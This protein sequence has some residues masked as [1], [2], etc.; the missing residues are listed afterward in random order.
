M[1]ENDRTMMQQNDPKNNWYL[2]SFDRFEKSLNG[3][4]KTNLHTIRKEAIAKFT[5]I[6]FPTTHDEEWKYTDVSPISRMEFKP[7]LEQKT[8]GLTQEDI[9]RLSFGIPNVLVLVNGRFSKELSKLSGLP[10]NIRAGS[11]ADALRSGG[12]MLE[13]H[14][15]RHARY[16]E[17]AF[18][19]LNTAFL[20]DGAFIHIPEKMILSEPIHLLFISTENAEPF[21]SHP[22]NLI[23]AEKSCQATILES[24]V[25]VGGST[26]FTNTVSEIVVSENAVLEH[27]KFQMESEQAFHVA[28]INAHQ[29]R[30]STYTQHVITMGGLLTRNNI[31]SVLDGE[32]IESTLNG[33]YLGTADQHIDNHTVIDHAKPHCN[34]HE[35]YKGILSGKSRGV[36]NG[37]IFVRKDAQ[38]T[39]AKQ[40]NKNLV[41][42]DEA[43]IDSKPQLEIFANDVKCTHGATIGQLDDEAIFYLRSRGVDFAKAR[44]ILI[45]AFASDVVDRLKIEP[46]RDHLHKLIHDRLEEERTPAV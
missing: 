25:S 35:L 13:Q 29:D 36:F 28:T 4:A 21:V 17:N 22:R 33:L 14:L 37:K 2:S 12:A 9:E 27:D 45:F 15:T 11:L 10:K 8:T 39:D 42:S 40:T 34:S 46:L 23:I 32:G 5:E 43:S 18:I 41:L 3:E 1:M 20:I 16:D 38:K 19:A 31:T 6:G 26:Y 44:D 30:N 7:I 24:Y